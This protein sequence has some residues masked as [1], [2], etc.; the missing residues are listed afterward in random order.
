[1]ASLLPRSLMEEEQ[2]LDLFTHPKGTGAAV[3]SPMR[4]KERSHLIQV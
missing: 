3:A 2:A 1:M 4:K